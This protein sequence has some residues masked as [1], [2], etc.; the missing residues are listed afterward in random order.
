MASSW[1]FVI[2]KYFQLGHYFS[3]T[4]DARFPE[5]RS[6]QHSPIPTDNIVDV[7]LASG[8]A[9][10]NDYTDFDILLNAVQTAGLV[11]ALAA[12][13]A[14]LTVFAPNDAAFVRLARDLGF[15]GFDETGAFSAIVDAGLVG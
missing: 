4:W 14:D 12:V 13:D 5:H 11:D 3:I 15:R 8:G 9:F 2:K 7:V 1:C 6:G 10:D